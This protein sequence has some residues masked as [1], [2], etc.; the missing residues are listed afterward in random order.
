MS[1]SPI[2]IYKGRGTAQKPQ[3]RYDSHAREA[4]DDGWARV[5]ESGNDERAP[6]PQTIVVERPARTIITRND[7]PDLP[8]SQSINPYL[9]CEHGCIYCS[10]RAPGWG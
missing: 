9:G 4:A 2:R 3:P 5:D 10:R 8:F 1:Q 7:S 6:A